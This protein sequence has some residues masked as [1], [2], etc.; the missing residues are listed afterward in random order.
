MGKSPMKMVVTTTVAVAAVTYQQCFQEGILL[1]D[2]DDSD[3]RIAG[4]GSGTDPV[5]DADVVGLSV[6]RFGRVAFSVSTLD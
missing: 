5:R 2:P 4:N 1:A 6:W 3:G